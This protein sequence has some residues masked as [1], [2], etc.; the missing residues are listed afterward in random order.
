[1]L[2]LPLIQGYE[3]ELRVFPRLTHPNVLKALGYVLDKGQNYYV[4]SEWMVRGSL[5]KYIVELTMQERFAMV[6]CNF[7][8]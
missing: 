3:K 2:N 1:M 6:I 4:V 8:I 5:C 7:F